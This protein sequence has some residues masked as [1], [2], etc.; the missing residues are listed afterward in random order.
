MSKKFKILISYLIISFI[1]Q[2]CENFPSSPVQ[3]EIK[4]NNNFKS[5]VI[6][7]CGNNIFPSKEQEL[8]KFGVRFC[9]DGKEYLY[10]GRLVAHWWSYFV[11]YGEK[12]L[13]ND[14][15]CSPNNYLYENFGYEPAPTELKYKIDTYTITLE[16]NFV[17]CHSYKIYSLIN[18]EWILLD[19]IEQDSESNNIITQYVIE[20]P[21]MTFIGDSY[22]KGPTY[23]VITELF[24]KYRNE[25][26]V[27]DILYPPTRI[28]NNNT[29]I[30]NN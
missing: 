7:Y 4:N 15:N 11:G 19:E 26:N 9:P 5:L 24:G 25:S 6:N 22:I 21:T 30:I 18:N 16:W 23:K 10:E 28:Y 20:K 14:N 1:I 3:N 8:V 2:S 12:F 29:G 27:V 17:F 13:P